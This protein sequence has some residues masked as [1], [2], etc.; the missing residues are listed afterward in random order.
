MMIQ[1]Q[2]DQSRKSDHKPNM[3]S[4]I[5]NCYEQM[6]LD[7]IY[8]ISGEVFS[9]PPDQDVIADLTCLALN[10]LPARYVRHSVDFLAHL[11]SADGIQMH[12]NVSKAVRNAITVLQR[13]QEGER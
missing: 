12:D 6:V 8:R 3:L 10:Q 13:R 9:E 5:T 2:G 7:E 11:S 4:S 1:N